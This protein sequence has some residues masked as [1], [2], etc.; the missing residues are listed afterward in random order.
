MRRGLKR[1]RSSMG[2]RSRNK[3]YSTEQRLK[4][5]NKKLKRQISQL[6]KLISRINLAEYENL[7]DA[8]V[9]QETENQIEKA[10]LEEK[11]KEEAWKCYH[12]EN[13]IL[14]L[15]TLGLANGVR[16]WRKC[17]NCSHRTKAKKYTQDVE[18]VE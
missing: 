5:E 6:K 12:C 13:G 1:S 7:K 16:Y 18:G 10:I 8:I 15:K 9:Q 3:D 14:R 4:H 17:D 2:K 11:K